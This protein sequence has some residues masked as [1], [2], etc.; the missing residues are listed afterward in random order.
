[1][2]PT[3]FIAAFFLF[4]ASSASIGA[5]EV[6]TLAAEIDAG[7]LTAVRL[8]ANVGDVVVV[9]I[10]DGVVRVEAN[11][12]P[13]RGG[14]FSSLKSAEKQVR[15]ATLETTVS[16]DV[17]TVRVTGDDDRRFEEDW[18]LSLPPA[19]AFDLELGVGDVSISG[20]S[21]GVEVELGVGGVELDL[22]DGSVDV[23]VGVGNIVTRARATAFRSVEASSGVGDT[24]IETDG[25][26]ITGEG[27]VGHS[28][29]WNGEGRYHVETATGVG[30]IRIVL[31]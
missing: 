19:L 21:G 23:E 22:A 16:G 11:L 17:L 12:S 28:A 10:D 24:R 30:D 27:F 6:R 31:E 29:E 1:M 26:R 18:T 4:C 8:E 15:E 14:L 7:S 2:K 5:V 3:T 9:A 13:R 25:A 20:L